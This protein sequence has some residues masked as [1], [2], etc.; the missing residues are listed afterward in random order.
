MRGGSRFDYLG[1][2][3]VLPLHQL[4]HLVQFTGQQGHLGMGQRALTYGPSAPGRSMKR[5]RQ[6]SRD[7]LDR[8]LEEAEQE[9]DQEDYICII[10]GRFPE[11][12]INLS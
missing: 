11:I 10:Y 9:S 4:G 7:E 6:D 8:F 2:P 5:G 3:P 1:L 12:A